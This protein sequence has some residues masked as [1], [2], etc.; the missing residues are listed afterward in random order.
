MTL[1]EII[2]DVGKGIFAIF[3]E[4]FNNSFITLFPDVDAGTLDLLVKFRHGNK[5][6]LDSVSRESY[7][8]IVKAVIATNVDAWMSVHNTL[9]TDY[10]PTSSTETHSKLGTID[11]Q[12]DNN[13]TTLNAEK[14]FNDT[15]FVDAE[16]SASDNAFSNKDTYNITET[17]V[18]SVGNV[19]DNIKK[20]IQLRRQMNFCNDVTSD[21]VNELT[22]KIYV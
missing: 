21:I 1:I 15:D 5:N 17:N 11:R 13:Q 9:N 18:K 14:V 10:S 22:L 4:Y 2:N 3:A 8:D 16:K 6:V 20:E 12:G 19:I 7:E